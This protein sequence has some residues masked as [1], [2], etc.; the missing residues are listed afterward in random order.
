MV[1][2][3]ILC[4]DKICEPYV[5]EEEDC[6]VYSGPNCS[7]PCSVANCNIE[8]LDDFNYCTL[9]K[10]KKNVPPN[11]PEKL[12]ALWICLGIVGALLFLLCMI[13]YV[14]R[15]Q[16]RQSQ[17]QEYQLGEISQTIENQNFNVTRSGHFSILEEDSEDE[18]LSTP[19][20]RT[21]NY[22]TVRQ[23]Q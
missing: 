13:R 21:R 20:I 1:F 9:Y 5:I 10:C 19:I 3:Q 16:S 15:R 11:V 6:K 2:F 8:I 18:I 14:R 17:S 23:N 4:P 7:F 22:S 12:S